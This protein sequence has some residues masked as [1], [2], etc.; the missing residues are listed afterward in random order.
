MSFCKSPNSVRVG[1]EVQVLGRGQS[2]VNNRKRV[3]VISGYRAFNFKNA[4]PRQAVGAGLSVFPTIDRGER[5]AD[6]FGELRLSQP[7]EVSDTLYPF[8]VVEWRINRCDV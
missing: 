4:P 5:H 8:G 3:S 6:E 7:L 2:F 1:R